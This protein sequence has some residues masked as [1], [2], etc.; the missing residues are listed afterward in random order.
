MK[1]SFDDPAERILSDSQIEFKQSP[2]M[3]EQKQGLENFFAEI[4]F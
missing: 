4:S 3:I 1:L 2:K